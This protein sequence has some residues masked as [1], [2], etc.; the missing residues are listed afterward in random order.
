MDMKVSKL[1]E[2]VNGN[3]NVTIYT[4]GTKV[5]ETEGDEFHPLLD[6]L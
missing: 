3:Y 2:Y 5:R 4:D 6:Y 1:Y